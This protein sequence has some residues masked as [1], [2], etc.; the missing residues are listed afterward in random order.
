MKKQK[1]KEY[2]G[3]LQPSENPFIVLYMEVRLHPIITKNTIT[4]TP[5]FYQ[6]TSF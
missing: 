6:A 4:I 5:T 2:Q 1:T 3:L